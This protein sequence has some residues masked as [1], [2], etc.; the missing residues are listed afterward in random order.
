MF[1]WL[2]ARLQQRKVSR[3]LVERGAGEAFLAGYLKNQG[4]PWPPPGT[5]FI[6][7][8]L[9]PTQHNWFPFSVEMRPPPGE[10][11]L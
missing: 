2:K 1:A 7:T 4:L 9:P 10:K 6:I 8:V 5:E 11:R 3:A